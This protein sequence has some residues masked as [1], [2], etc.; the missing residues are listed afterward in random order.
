MIPLSERTLIFRSV[1]ISKL[2][3]GL[4]TLCL[5]SAHWR[6][7]ERASI[8]KQRRLL[9][10][11]ARG[12]TNMWVREMCQT[13]TIQSSVQIQRLRILRSI[14]L[15]SGDLESSNSQLP[16]VLFGEGLDSVQIER[17]GACTST[18]NPWLLQFQ[19]DLF[20]ASACGAVRDLP[21]CFAALREHRSF[22]SANFHQLRS[23]RTGTSEDMHLS[24]TPTAAAAVVCSVCFTR[25]QEPSWRSYSHDNDSFSANTAADAGEE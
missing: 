25:I 6:K 21:L 7:L 2:L 24:T 15:M 20:A 10:G 16:A 12:H 3:S 9:C 4:E 11:Q 18:A 8:G 5:R 1:V 19:T 22:L 13:W 17:N 23:Y 14:I